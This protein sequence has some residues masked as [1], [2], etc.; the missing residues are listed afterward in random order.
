VLSVSNLQCADCGSV[1][2]AHLFTLKTNNYHGGLCAYSV[3]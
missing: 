2:R 1:P 3:R